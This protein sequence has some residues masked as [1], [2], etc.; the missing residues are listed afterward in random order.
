MAVAVML[1]IPDAFVVAVVEDSAALAPVNG[2]AN[3]TVTP[4]TGLLPA[5]RTVTCNGVANAAPIADDCGVP[6]VATI[7]AGE[8]VE[9]V[10]TKVAG[11]ATPAALAVTL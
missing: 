9:L 10:S 2:A 7:A 11:V 1:A 5:S 8:P 6:P 4:L 3:V